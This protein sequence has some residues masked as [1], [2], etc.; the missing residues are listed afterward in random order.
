MDTGTMPEKDAF[1]CSSEKD[2]SL[3]AGSTVILSCPTVHD[4]LEKCIRDTGCTYEVHELEKSSHNF[5]DRLR[6]QLQAEI[7]A[8]QDY[9][10]ILMSFGIC[11]NA[12]CGLT[13]SHAELVIPKVDDCVSL[14]MGGVKPRLESLNGKFGIFL[15]AGW[16][17]Y[18]ENIWDE[19]C[20]TKQ[21][22]S[23]KRAAK[24]LERMFGEMTY[25]TVLD[26]GAYDLAEV[27]KKAEKIAEALHLELRIIK[28]NLS[29]LSGLLKGSWDTDRYAV[30]PPGTATT[31]AQIM[32]DYS[33]RQH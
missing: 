17:R 30:F 22:Y 27:L 14:L 1:F 29:L 9:D 32:P 2:A 4:E 12:A 19:I 31:S 10:R 5:P 7:D 8:L 33:F 3:S 21:R 15:T 11:G 13:S 25:L 24:I 16:L 20:R 28:G 6:N 26:T 23:E 18:E